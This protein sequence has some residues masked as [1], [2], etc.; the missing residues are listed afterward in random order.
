MMA[1][2]KER[3]QEVLITFLENLTVGAYAFSYDLL[4]SDSRLRG[5]LTKDEWIELHKTWQEQA[6]PRGYRTDFG[7]ILKPEYTDTDLTP[8]NEE[9]D[10]NLVKIEIGWS[11]SI[12]DTPLNASICELPQPTAINQVTGRRWFWALYTL[13]K[14]RGNWRVQSMIDEVAGAQSLSSAELQER[15]SQHIP[16]VKEF[17]RQHTL[18]DLEK[19]SDDPAEI[20]ALQEARGRTGHVLAYLDALIE[21]E[22]QELRRYELAAARALSLNEIERCLVY[23]DLMLERFPER[24]SDTLLLLSGVQMRYIQ[25]LQDRLDI[26]DYEEEFIGRMRERAEANL[27]ESISLNDNSMS[28][29]FLAQLL[30][31]DDEHLE[32]AEEQLRRA[33]ALAPDEATVAMAEHELGQ[34]AMMREDYEQALEHYRRVAEIHPDSPKAWADIGDAFNAMEQFDEAEANYKH[35][36]ELKPDAINLYVD[37]STIYM[38]NDEMDRSRDLWEE[39][40]R[41]NPGSASCRYYLA[42]TLAEQGEFR[43]AQ[44]LLEEAQEIDPQSEMAVM[45]DM[46]LNA[47]K[48]RKLPAVKADEQ[49]PAESTITPVGAPSVVAH[50]LSGVRPPTKFSRKKARKRKKR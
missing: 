17:S 50:P 46:M 5:G 42:M 30:Q 34:L 1:R 31:E 43:R 13:V 18:S 29:L 23:F 44:K 47:F 12:N 28:H 15:I 7:R 2:K 38:A 21:Q 40:L 14:E 45:I 33:R 37:L 32:E 26:F 9:H 16:F 36:I 25:H 49:A 35:A 6:N 27:R 24:R 10:A 39:A 22:P 11:M 4:A 3:K 41:A 20:E 48:T 8:S 19:D